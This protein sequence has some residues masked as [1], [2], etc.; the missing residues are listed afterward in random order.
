LDRLQVVGL[1]F[2][3]EGMAQSGFG[4]GDGAHCYCC[5]DAVSFVVV[6]RR[7]RGFQSAWRRELKRGPR[8]GTRAPKDAFLLPDF[9]FV[10][11][12]VGSSIL[13][14][15]SEAGGNDRHKS[16]SKPLPPRSKTCED[17]LLECVHV[18]VTV[19]AGAQFKVYFFIVNSLMFVQVLAWLLENLLSA[20][21]FE[22]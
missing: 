18:F 1:V 13:A 14:S 3:A 17:R 4:L 22:S 5:S 10:A 6:I 16:W 19:H 7:L 8:L 20:S 9:F 2:I 15:L 11:R 21:Q 12:R